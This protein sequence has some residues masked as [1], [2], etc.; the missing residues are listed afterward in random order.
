MEYLK[1]PEEDPFSPS[2]VLTE[3][4]ETVEDVIDAVRSDGDQAV[5]ELTE[6][7]DGIEREQNRLTDDEIERALAELSEEQKRIIDHNHARIERFAEAQ[8]EHITSFE[9]SLGQGVSVGQRIV[10]IQR[11]GAYVPGGAYPLLSSALMAVTPPAVAGVENIT[12]ATPPRDDGIPHPA[13][14]YGALQAGADEIFVIG[15]AQAIA[16]MALGTKEVTAVDK[17]LGPGNAFV[18]E[19]KRQLF[20]TVGIDLLAGPSEILVI[21]DKS[22]DPV[23]VAADLLAQA[24]HDTAA[25]PLLVTTSETVGTSVIQEVS[26]QLVDL[27][28]ADI[29]G[30][31]WEKMGTVI[32]TDDLDEAITVA[33]ELA[34][35]HVEVHTANPRDLLN[36]LT[37]YGTL[38]LGENSA[39]VFSD[40]LTG[41]N[42]TLPTQRGARYTSGLSIH[43][44]IKTQTYQEVS[45][46]GVSLLEPWA[47]KQS[48]IEQL[49]GHSKSSYVRSRDHKLSNYD[50]EELPLPPEQ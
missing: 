28:T 4:A 10:P 32:T 48:K 5:M 13:V 35:E 38:F 26:N 40:K 15:G 44:V 27:K 6:K 31:S 39:N 2:I 25:R 8:L 9:M 34:V 45:D 46:D 42:H 20:G 37:N 30:E 50:P 29:A 23:T 24:E 7:F 12:V 41:T 22:A 21:A 33:D 47:T 14:V 11:V 43:S 17:L 19:A 3:V 49:D 36:R 16:A 18:T 1:R